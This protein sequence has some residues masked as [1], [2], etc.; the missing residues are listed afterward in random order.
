MQASAWLSTM[1]HP[2]EASLNAFLMSRGQLP[3]WY[4]ASTHSSGKSG[5]RSRHER[6]KNLCKPLL[7]NSQRL[8][9]DLQAVGSKLLCALKSANSIGSRE[10][11]PT[12]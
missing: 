6:K 3:G 11:M 9:A 10:D 2:W 12:S 8:G 1:C 4:A 5:G 7:P